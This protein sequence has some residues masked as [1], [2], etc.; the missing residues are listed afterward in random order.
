MFYEFFKI[1]DPVAR[2]EQQQAALPERVRQFIR[3]AVKELP[4]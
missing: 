4:A 2:D 3:S 1:Y